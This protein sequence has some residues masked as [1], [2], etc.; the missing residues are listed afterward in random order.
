MTFLVLLVS[1]AALEYLLSRS[2]TGHKSE[3]HEKQGL[4]SNEMTVPNGQ[5][6]SLAESLDRLGQVVEQFGRG[7]VPRASPS[8]PQAARS[9][10][11]AKKH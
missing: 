3:R 4:N 1:I 2:E 9:E 5:P 10:V 7:S 8:A 11:P 6:A